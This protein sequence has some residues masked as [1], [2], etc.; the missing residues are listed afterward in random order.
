MTPIPALGD[1]LPHARRARCRFAERDHSNIVRWTMF[2]RGGHFAAHK[3][4]A[5]LV[6]D[7]QEFFASLD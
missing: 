7:I 6:G 1:A 2:D 4:P 5:W 3:E